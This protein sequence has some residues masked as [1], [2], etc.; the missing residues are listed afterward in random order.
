MREFISS[1]LK[2]I[3]VTTMADILDSTYIGRLIDQEFV[4]DLPDNMDIC[5]ENGEY[6]TFCYDGDIF[7]YPVPYSLGEPFLKSYSYRLDDGSEKEHSYWFA[8]LQDI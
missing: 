8:N 4:S 2:T 3:V 7:N 6:H 5:G 1:G